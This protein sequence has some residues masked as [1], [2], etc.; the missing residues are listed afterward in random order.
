[1]TYQRLLDV[2]EMDEQRPG[3]LRNAVVRSNSPF[4]V[5]DAEIHGDRRPSL[6]LESPSKLFFRSDVPRGGELRFGLA[7]RKP[8]CVWVIRL[9]PMIMIVCPDFAVRSPGSHLQGGTLR[10]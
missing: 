8:V 3:S 1:M 9:L 2:S 7:V 6:V 4:E 10:D 5:H